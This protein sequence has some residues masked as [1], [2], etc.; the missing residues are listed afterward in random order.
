MLRDKDDFVTQRNIRRF[1]LMLKT[2]I[3]PEKRS[4][5]ERLLLEERLKQAKAAPVQPE[6]AD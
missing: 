6:T 3:D 5:L 2:E 4:T 1:S